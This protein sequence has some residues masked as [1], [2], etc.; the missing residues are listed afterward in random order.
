MVFIVAPIIK[1]Q[2]RIAAE[3]NAAASALMIESLLVFKL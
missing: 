1:R 2:L 3:A